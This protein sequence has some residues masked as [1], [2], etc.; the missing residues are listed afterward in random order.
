MLFTLS[1]RLPIL[2]LF[3]SRSSKIFFPP[4]TFPCTHFPP[5]PP[6]YQFFPYSIPRQ[7]RIICTSSC[8]GFHRST[9]NPLMNGCPYL[10]T[11]SSL[12][13]LSTY[14]PL[15]LPRT[16]LGRMSLHS[17]SSSSTPS[18]LP[19]SSIPSITPHLIL[20]IPSLPTLIL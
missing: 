7:P 20:L 6:S 13:Q 1:L 14:S 17:Q 11:Q 8:I 19:S 5:P 18:H 10:S 9:H 4:F 12:P 16:L 15:P 3:P 2:S